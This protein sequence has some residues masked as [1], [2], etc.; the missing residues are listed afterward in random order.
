RARLRLWRGSRILF[1]R[2]A[3]VFHQRS[4]FDRA[5]TNPWDSRGDTDRLVEIL[6]LNEKIS[7]ELFA[8]L[9]EPTV[10]DEPFAVAAPDAGCRR[11]WVQRGSVEILPARVELV[12][13]LYRLGAHPLLLGL[14]EL[15]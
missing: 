1:R 7:A 13:E 3:R 8:R 6:R 15:A 10:R 12:R 5:D 4:D 2:P 11:R 14:A 9:R